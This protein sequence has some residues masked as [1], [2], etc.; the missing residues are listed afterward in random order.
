MPIFEINTTALDK[1]VEDKLRAEIK[2]L[3]QDNKML[4]T[5]QAPD[6][7]TKIKELQEENKTLKQVNKALQHQSDAEHTRFL[8]E[9]NKHSDNLCMIAE[10]LDIE[11]QGGTVDILD[12]IKTVK[13]H[14]ED[15]E[16]ELLDSRESYNLQQMSDNFWYK[17][18]EAADHETG[19]N[20]SYEDYYNILGDC[21]NIKQENEKLKLTV[22]NYHET[23][24][25]LMSESCVPNDTAFEAKVIELKNDNRNKDA[26]IVRLTNE[27]KDF[28]IKNN[29]FKMKILKQ[30]KEIKAHS[31]VL[32][33]VETLS[34]LLPDH[35]ANDDW[36]N[37]PDKLEKLVAERNEYVDLIK[38]EVQHQ[39]EQ[40]VLL[41]KNCAKLEDELEDLK[42]EEEQ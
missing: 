33:E 32:K 42:E 27:I 19:E 4:L 36:L 3:K 20:I 7:A 31:A 15:L 26:T 37:H 24:S 25:Y 13:Q 6:T 39:L 11:F 22:S 9:Q 8:E 40:R 5:C 12:E 38:K 14:Q 28:K 10:T 21:W 17:G 30:N 16:S 35:S 41:S 18:E 29:K 1:H 23:Q 2:T 34:L